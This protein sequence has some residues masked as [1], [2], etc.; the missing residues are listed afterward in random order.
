MIGERQIEGFQALTLSSEEAP[1]EA[2]VVPAAGMVGCSLRHDG[3]ELLGQR[4][5]LTH[6][7]SHRSTMGIP[8]LHPWANRLSRARFA[9]NGREVALDS[10]AVPV[11][12]DPNGLPI[13]GLLAGASGWR[14]ERDEVLEQGGVLAASFDFGARA[15]LL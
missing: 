11:A 4:G 2:A 8:L 15:D 10:A 5:G 9:L 12:F 7:V 13:H 14:V 1:I 6:Y 3:E